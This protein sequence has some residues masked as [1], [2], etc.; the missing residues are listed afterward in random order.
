MPDRDIDC[1]SGLKGR[2]RG[3]K[4]KE[5]KLLG[6][7]RAMR[8]GAAFSNILKACWEETLEAGIY[9]FEN[10]SFDWLP[11]LQADRFFTLIQIRLATFPDEDYSF[12]A[13]CTDDACSRKFEWDL[14]LADLPVK[15]VPAAT[16]KKLKDGQDLEV[17]IGGRKVSFILPDGKTEQRSA[18]FVKRDEI[19]MMGVLL[20]RITEVKGVDKNKYQS[21]LEE[22]GFAEHRDMLAAFDEADGGVETM[23]DIRCPHCGWEYE[24]DLPF[25]RAFFMPKS[26]KKAGKET[27]KRA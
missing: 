12:S 4:G 26:K 27:T 20:T 1:P 7:K 14:D 17:T 13:Q 2:I 11:V 5:F 9:D 23:I 25:G 24:V 18:K 6:D 15:K 16:L 8:S 3:L 10:G 21:W 22:L 19:D